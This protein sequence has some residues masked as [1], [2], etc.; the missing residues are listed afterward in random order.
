MSAKHWIAMAAGAMFALAL[1]VTAMWAWGRA[2]TLTLEAT[3][4]EV[5]RWAIRSAAVGAAAM[6]QLLLLTLVAGQVYRRRTAT[7]S[8][9]RFAT[10]SIACIALVSAAALGLAGR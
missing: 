3:R 9:L 7:S 6:A 8:L 4:P 5:A 10:G 2:G 1:M